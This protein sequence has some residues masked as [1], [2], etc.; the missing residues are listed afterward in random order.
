MPTK[1]PTKS[2]SNI[3]TLIFQIQNKQTTLNDQRTSGG[4]F[5]HER[6]EASGGRDAQAD[7]VVNSKTRSMFVRLHYSAFFFYKQRLFTINYTLT[8]NVVN[9]PQKVMPDA[10]CPLSITLL[11]CNRKN[12][13]YLTFRYSKSSNNDNMIFSIKKN[14][15]Y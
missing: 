15:Y 10:Q 4:G 11:C 6:G 2:S 9:Y 14:S 3:H 1:L 13:V 5:N 8:L 7:N 12:S